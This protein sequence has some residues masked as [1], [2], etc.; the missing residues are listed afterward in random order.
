MNKINPITVIFIGRSGSGKGTQA[1]KFAEYL[2]NQYM[3]PV[4]HLESGALFRDFIEKDSGYTSS[5]AKQINEEGK[6]Q[7]Q[8]LSAMM[9]SRALAD[10]I[11]EE[12]HLIIDGTPRR[13][14]EA[15]VLETAFDFY[16]R[17]NIYVVH[18]DVSKGEA[19]KRLQ[20]RGRHDDVEMDD[21]LERLSWFETDVM[22]VIQYYRDTDYYTFIEVDGMKSIEDIQMKVVD[23]IEGRLMK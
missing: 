2:K 4:Y 6:L 14:D 15:K 5:L 22:P 8:F 17:E 9:W 18:L 7:P 19:V 1:K 11:D 16:K 10:N 23:E 12:T 13:L 21:V 20:E 3:N